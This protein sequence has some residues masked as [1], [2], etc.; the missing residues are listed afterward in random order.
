V[1][2]AAREVLVRHEVMEIFS[3]PRREAGSGPVGRVEAPLVNRGMA[4]KLSS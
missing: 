1:E 3:E 2:R 4:S